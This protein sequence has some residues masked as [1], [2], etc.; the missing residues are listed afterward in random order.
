M[1]RVNDGRVQ[2][3]WDAFKDCEVPHTN[4]VV[5]MLGGYGVL[6]TGESLGSVSCRRSCNGGLRSL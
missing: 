4:V 1:H 3:Q 6:G 2:V 5:R